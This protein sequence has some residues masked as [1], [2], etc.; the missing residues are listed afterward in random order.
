VSNS[1]PTVLIVSAEP[2]IGALLGLYVEFSGWRPAFAGEEQSSADA[3]AQCDPAVI[4]V[5]LEH[6]DGASPHFIAHERSRGRRV[7][8]FSSRARPLATWGRPDLKTVPAFAMPIDAA[9]FQTVLA[10]AR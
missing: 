2:I 7:I 8:V 4:L 9:S 1:P 10:E 6:R 5:D 3:V